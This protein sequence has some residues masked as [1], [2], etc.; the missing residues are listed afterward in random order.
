LLA[1]ETTKTMEKKKRGTGE[2]NRQ[3]KDILAIGKDK[4][5]RVVW[6]GGVTGDS[7]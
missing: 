2:Q 4:I 6:D 7:W 3:G 5:S 1:Q